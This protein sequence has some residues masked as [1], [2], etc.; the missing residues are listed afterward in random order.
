MD[1][2]CC[3]FCFRCRRCFRCFEEDDSSRE[4]PRRRDPARGE[5]AQGLEGGRGRGASSGRRGGPRA[6]VLVKPQK[7]AAAKEEDQRTRQ[8]P[9]IHP[10][11]AGPPVLA[12]EVVPGCA[13]HLR[14]AAG[15]GRTRR[16]SARGPKPSLSRSRG[17]GTSARSGDPFP[18]LRNLEG[19]LKN[20]RHARAL[21]EER[22]SALSG[23][24]RTRP[25]T[26]GWCGSCCE[27]A[28]LKRLSEL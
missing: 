22:P 11:C 19:T 3:C 15:R 18:S 17:R 1:S 10:P 21:E 12:S 6:R 7:E 2:R 9:S 27:E 28:K 23:R 25:R 5:G 8:L 14:R 26:R 13:L 20:G 16:R 4:G 24:R